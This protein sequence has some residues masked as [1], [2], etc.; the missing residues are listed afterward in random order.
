MSLNF[1]KTIEDSA[2]T[3]SDGTSIYSILVEDVKAGRLGMD[4]SN[5]KSWGKTDDKL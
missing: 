4:R 3:I 1:W 5:T 2:L